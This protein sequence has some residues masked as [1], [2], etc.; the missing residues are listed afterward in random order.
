MRI[1]TLRS[2]QKLK[3]IKQNFARV[4]LFL[5]ISGAKHFAISSSFCFSLFT[6]GFKL[7]LNLTHKK[8][9]II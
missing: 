6:I 2:K 7:K 5:V 4:I 8:K 3:K 9:E 1:Y